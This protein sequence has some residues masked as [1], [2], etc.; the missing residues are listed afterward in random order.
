MPPRSLAKFHPTPATLRLAPASQSY[1]SYS[2]ALCAGSQR[3]EP[4]IAHPFVRFPPSPIAS[5]QHPNPARYAEQLGS[6]HPPHRTQATQS[7]E[8]LP[9]TA[10][11]AAKTGDV[12]HP[13]RRQALYLLP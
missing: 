4:P 13:S 11:E 8:D 10:R 1:P 5:A 12:E 6:E 3:C 7:R 2:A 9:L